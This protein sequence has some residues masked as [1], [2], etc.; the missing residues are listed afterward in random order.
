MNGEVE[1]KGI[2]FLKTKEAGELLMH[3]HLHIFLCKN[4]TGEGIDG[5]W[6]PV[7][8]FQPEKPMPHIEQSLKIAI[9]P[10]FTITHSDLIKEGDQYTSY[11]THCFQNFS[12]K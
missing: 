12:Q 1:Y 9:T 4:P 7:K 8:P 3:H 10:G 11:I 6:I 5:E 2:E